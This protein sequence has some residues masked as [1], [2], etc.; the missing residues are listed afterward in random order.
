[1]NMPNV[2]YLLSGPTTCSTA[3]S[4]LTSPYLVW[5]PVA[6]LVAITIMG[7]LG[8][9]YALSG[10]IGRND[11]RAWIRIKMFDTLFSL[12]LIVVFMSMGTLICAVNP[13]PALQSAGLVTNGN[14]H[15]TQ[16]NC[17]SE[18][19]LYG[20]ATC[21]IA[22]FSGAAVDLNQGIFDLAVT[23]GSVP[24]IN[25]DYTLVY[26]LSVGFD[27]WTITPSTVDQNMGFVVSTL[28]ALVMLNDVQVFLVAS[29]LLIFGVFMAIGLIARI[30]GVTRSFGG[31]MIAFAIGLG[32]VYP[33]LV[34]VTYGFVLNTISITEGSFW[35]LVSTFVTEFVTFSTTLYIASL[36][37]QITAI[38]VPITAFLSISAL[39]G[40][41]VAAFTINETVLYI[42]MI[43]VGL[44][45]IPFLNFVIVDA[46]I[47]DFSQA[48]GERMD[49]LS[50]LGSVI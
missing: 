3:S 38:I 42:G 4:L 39:I 17:Q 8:I 32:L 43:L 13:E 18:T 10:T 28:Y 25:I 46:F 23:I 48:I 26:G 27:G 16:F 1:M 44:T 41:V 34:A 33:M 49:F 21:D 14:Y 47:V 7:F 45:F 9:I 19:D 22:A 15:G 24:N 20:I 2:Y 37:S 40:T 36:S 50:L 35:I 30:F 11:L 31:A 5:G 6:A 29:S 12:I